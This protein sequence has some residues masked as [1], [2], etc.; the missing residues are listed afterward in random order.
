MR[1]ALIL[2]PTAG[3]SPLA[4]QKGTEKTF[5]QTLRETLHG[6]GIDADVYY[7]TAEDAGQGIAGRLVAEGT[8]MIVAVGG[9]GT[10]H[11]VAQ[12]LANSNCLLGIIPAGT[13]NNLALSLGIPEN[14]EEACALLTNGETRSIDV[15]SINGHIFLEVAGVG[16]EAAIFPAAEDVKSR[17]IF[18]TCK[19]VIGGLRAL[20]TFRPPQMRLTFDQERPRCYQAIQLTVCNAPYYGVHLNI[21]PEIRMNDGWLDAVLYRNFS[22][23][24][25][26][27]HAVS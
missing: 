26:I 4:S 7:T 15:G 23:R 25:Y 3:S 2:N 19:G 6:Q 10:I 9:D 11:S 14:L 21:A 17:N 16:L 18:A 8:E 12:A 20:L 22:K 24:E 1:T 27:R 13:M 5:E